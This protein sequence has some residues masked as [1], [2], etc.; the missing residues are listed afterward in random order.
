MKG[1]LSHRRLVM[2]IAPV[3]LATLSVAGI[4]AAAGTVPTITVLSTRA[5]LVSGGDA[6]TSVTL[7]TGTSPSSVHML[8]NGQ[9]I[10]SVFAVRPNNLYEGLV[11]GLTLG[12]N[13]LVAEIPGGAAQLTI[14]NHPIGGPVFAGP[15]IQPWTCQTGA[16]DAQCN[17]PTTFAYQYKQ[18]GTGQFQSYDPSNPPPS[19]EIAS[20]MTDNGQT[21]PYI[22]RIETGYQD[23][24]EYQVAVLFNP[25]A[26]WQPWAPQPQWDGKLEIPGGASCGVNHGASTPPSVTDDTALSRGMM[27]AAPTLDNN[28]QNCNIVVQAEAVEMMKEHIVDDYGTIRYTIG[29]GCSGG[30]IYQQQLANAYPGLLDGILPMCSFPDSWSTSDDPFDCALVLPY[31][32]TQTAASDA[33]TQTEEAAVADDSSTSVCQSWVNVYM[34]SQGGNPSQT[35]S[36]IVACGVGATQP[37]NPNTEYNA[38]TNPGGVRCDLQDYMPN[39][40]GI[41]PQSEWDTQEQEVGHGFVNR[42][43]DNTGV[44]YGLNALLAGTISAQQ[45]ADLNA[46]VGCFDL[47]LNPI[48]ARC[49]GDIGGL[50]GVYRSGALNEANNMSTVP[51]LDLRGFDDSEIHSD[52]RSYV[53]RARLDAQFGGHGNQGIWTGPVALEGFESPSGSMASQGFL[54]MDQWLSAIQNDHGSA[55]MAQKV[56]NDKPAAANDTCFDTAG[57]PL[58]DQ[59]L[60][61]SVYPYFGAP[62]IDAGEPFTDDVMKCE[63]K[64]LD[65]S[66]FPG[67]TFTTA[68]WT[69]LQQTF[70]T[71]V[72]DW[73]KSGVDQKPTTPWQTY[74]DANGN[75]IYGGQPLGPAPVSQPAGSATNVPEALWAAPLLLVGVLI[76]TLG[77]ARR[78]ASS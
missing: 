69:A 57:N 22:I 72:C 65:M 34:Y 76:A 60:C 52:F 36:T 35:N 25:S 38:S 14:T 61:G 32:N 16:V 2:A 46:G 77:V 26:T 4:R 75:V 48:A 11:T 17:Q 51:I 29:S 68:E 78:R 10:T 45:F 58:A 50:D 18:T 64:P 73:S 15:Q 33:W 40:L 70:P 71:G 13:S 54:V 24:D 28:G 6:L 7:P 5:D 59:S 56:I 66:E 23:R 49:N 1:H 3:V 43:W 53:M 44:E 19:N 42:P 63:L 8:L 47:D 37:G 30:S 20:T 31:W 67:I 21:V 9:D 12:P 39:V 27:V 62:R 74:Q 55:S 41:R